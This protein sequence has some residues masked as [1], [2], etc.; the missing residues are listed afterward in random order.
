MKNNDKALGAFMEKMAEA[1]ERLEELMTYVDN[2]MDTH[3]DEINW[4]NV[5]SAEYMVARLT[6]LTDWGFHRGEYAE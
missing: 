6:E 1:R 4:G 3:P 2:H 5:G